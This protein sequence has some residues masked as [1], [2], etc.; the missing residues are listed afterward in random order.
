MLQTLSPLTETSKK[1]RGKG[2]GTKSR[3]SSQTSR[4]GGDFLGSWS[5]ELEDRNIPKKARGTGLEKKGG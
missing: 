2:G 4:R 3:G 1:M 5:G